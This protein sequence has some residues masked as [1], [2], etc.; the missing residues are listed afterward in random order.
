MDR[1]LRAPLS[2]AAKPGSCTGSAAP[3]TVALSSPRMPARSY[4]IVISLIKRKSTGRITRMPRAL[5]SLFTGSRYIMLMVHCACIR[6]QM[7]HAVRF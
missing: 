6:N 5:A 3:E 1:Y 4:P 7:R 2:G